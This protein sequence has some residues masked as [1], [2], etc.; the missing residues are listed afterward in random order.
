[1]Y[2]PDIT[3]LHGICFSQL[4]IERM[5]LFILILSWRGCVGPSAVVG[6]SPISLDIDGKLR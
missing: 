2:D 3:G 6:C 5:F 1:M 4:R